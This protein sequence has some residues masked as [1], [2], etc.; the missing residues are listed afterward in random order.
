[1]LPTLYRGPY[2]GVS[3]RFCMMRNGCWSF[4]ARSKTSDGLSFSF[5]V[6]LSFTLQGGQLHLTHMCL[7]L[8][9]IHKGVVI[10][11]VYKTTVWTARV[12][13]ASI[14]W[15]KALNQLESLAV[16]RG[17]PLNIYLL[18]KDGCTLQQT[19]DYK[20]CSTRWYQKFGSSNFLKS[21]TV[22]KILRAVS[23]LNCHANCW[24]KARD[25]SFD[26]CSFPNSVIRD[27]LKIALKV[28]YKHIKS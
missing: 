13:M 28:R 22:S 2:D 16:H 19:N 14:S 9:S 24:H 27:F 12:A 25:W 4:F 23:S 11:Y 8:Y 17:L 7:L 1:M 26:S 6:G 15:R 5:I 3:R 18:Y 21:I 20:S 10:K